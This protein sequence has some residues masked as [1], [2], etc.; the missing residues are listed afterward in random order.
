MMN[1][2]L[3]IEQRMGL[4]LIA[5]NLVLSRF[6]AAPSFVLGFLLGLGITLVLIGSLP[7]KAYG[8]LKS[9][10]SAILHRD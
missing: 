8:A 4:A 5:A 10:K 1:R 3:R 6:T 2:K 7:N 9:R